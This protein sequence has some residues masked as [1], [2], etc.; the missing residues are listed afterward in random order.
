MSDL[1]SPL[2]AFSNDLADC[3]AATAARIL[4]LRSGRRFPSSGLH[5]RPGLIVTSDEALER[6]DD[7]AVLR[8]DG[9]TVTATLVGRDPTTDIA[10]L[11]FEPDGLSVVESGGAAALRAGNL[12]LAVGRNETGPL[13]SLGVAALASGE[14]HSM[15]GGTIDRLIRLD[16]RLSPSAEGGAMVDAAGKVLGMTVRGPRRLVLGI[17]ASTIDRVVD[18]L[19]AK[20]RIA[21]GY[22]GAGLRPAQQGG[23]SGLLIVSIDPEGPAA[24]AGLLVGDMIMRWNGKPLARVR[25]AMLQLGPDSVGSA[26]VLALRRGGEP[27]EASVTIAERPRR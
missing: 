4:V 5:W 2:L 7:I 24:K 16:L 6:D 25:E 14:W 17:P 1:A 10:L 9:N 23:E 11:R 27:I 12:V 21:R 22:L 20:G 19:L 15:R 13:A 3:V 8:P 26:V 18:Q